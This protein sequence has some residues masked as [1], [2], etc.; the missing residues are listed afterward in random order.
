MWTLQFLLYSYVVWVLFLAVMA[1][2]AAWPRLPKVTRVLAVPAVA[3]AVILDVG[4]NIVAT[5]PFLDLPHEWT[6]SQR[7]GRYKHEQSWRTPIAC[8][9]CANLLD[10]FQVGGHCR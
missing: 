4:L 10:P 8:W 3:V 6:F 9:I 2:Y 5:I 1:L 7:M